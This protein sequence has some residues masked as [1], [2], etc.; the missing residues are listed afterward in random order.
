MSWKRD[1]C[2]VKKDRCV[3]ERLCKELYVFVKRALCVVQESV[4]KRDF[5]LVKRA[6]YIRTFA[7]LEPVQK[8]IDIVWIDII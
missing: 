2:V 4:V 1:L 6:E 5:C 8:G 7:A 3:A